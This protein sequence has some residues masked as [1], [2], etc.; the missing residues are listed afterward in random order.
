MMF[1]FQVGIFLWIIAGM[2]GIE[3]HLANKRGINWFGLIYL[4]SFPF[5][6]LFAHFCGLI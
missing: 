5:I 2:V 4:V 6:P 1:L 3:F